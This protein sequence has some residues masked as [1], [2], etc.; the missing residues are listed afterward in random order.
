VTE[1]EARFRA[2]L[3]DFLLDFDF[4][5]RSSG[6]TGLFGASG[7]GKTT[8][9]RCLAGLHRA[10]SG[11]VRLN[12]DV[13]QDE[14]AGVFVPPFRRGVG[15]VSQGA[16]LFPHLSVRENLSY[17]HRRVAEGQRVF[18]WEAV[19]QW[20]A[21]GPLL[22]RSV[23]NLSGGERQ[24]VAVAR[25]LLACPRL[26][27]MDEPVSALDE[28]AR[29]DVLKYLERILTQ[30]ELPVVYVSHSLTEV[31]RLSDHLVWIEGGRVNTAGPVSK[32]LGQLD[33]ARWWDEEAGVVLDGTVHD[34]DHHF[35]L[36]EVRTP[37]GDLTI[38]QRPEAP[39]TRVRVQVYARDVS[40][41]LAAQHGSS[42]LNELCLTVLQIV[43]LSPSD[44]LIRLGHQKGQEP[45]LLARITR[46]S[47][48]RLGLTAGTAVFARV[49]SVA[50][51]D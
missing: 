42:I 36:T 26:L 15:Y 45:V 3:G 48:S 21:L 11:L 5:A 6:V 32:V 44:C 37:L 28:P 27:L 35:H 9:L 14:A 22:E 46:K 16:D 17:A 49:K 25:A 8:V 1:L 4:T 30:L 31:A 33:F 2:R 18:G 24:R 50:V 38:H 29:R 12:G 20:L 40:L 13:W 41:G 10:E 19:V 47:C 51:L 34:H 23:P 39:G 43:D 7:S